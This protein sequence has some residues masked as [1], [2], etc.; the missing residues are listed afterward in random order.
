MP[1]NQFETL[2]GGVDPE[3]AKLAD[4]AWNARQEELKKKSVGISSE[5]SVRFDDPEW[6]KNPDHL[7]LM[8]APNGEELKR[9]KQDLE[10]VS[11]QDEERI[12]GELAK[13]QGLPESGNHGMENIVPESVARSPRFGEVRISQPATP[14]IPSILPSSEA[15]KKNG[16]FSSLGTRFRG[17]FGGGKKEIPASP[18]VEMSAPPTAEKAERKD[19]PVL[20]ESFLEAWGHGEQKHGEGQERNGSESAG[21]FEEEQISKEQ[22]EEIEKIASSR[23]KIRRYVSDFDFASNLGHLPRKRFM[24]ECILQGNA[25]ALF[26]AV[27]GD[28]NKKGKEMK[29]KGTALDEKE[30]PLHFLRFARNAEFMRDLIPDICY[31]ESE[32]SLARFVSRYDNDK[33]KEDFAIR[34]LQEVKRDKLPGLQPVIAAFGIK[35]DAVLRRVVT[36]YAKMYPTGS[37]ES[38]SDPGEDARFVERIIRSIREKEKKESSG[39]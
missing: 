32:M 33:V 30:K 20:S 24:Q 21:S 23:E 13:I 36:E 26:E 34:I 12:Q 22:L 3:K 17:W 39:A 29:E 9:L 8:K 4:E 2:R 7:Q 16:F 35:D 5:K 11:R 19:D 38:T 1:K 28:E 6:Q 37:A 15:P 14:E 27:L 31:K 10:R 25:N 18:A